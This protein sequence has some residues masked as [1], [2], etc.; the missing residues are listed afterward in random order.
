MLPFLQ[1]CTFR[2]LSSLELMFDKYIS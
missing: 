2:N 1:T